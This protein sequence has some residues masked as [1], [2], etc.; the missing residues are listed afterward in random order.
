MNAEFLALCAESEIEILQPTTSGPVVGGIFG[1][2]ADFLRAW[3]DGGL[4]VGDFWTWLPVIFEL[5][6]LVGPKIQEIIKIIKDAINRGDT[7]KVFDLTAGAA[8]IP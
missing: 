6:R 8:S 3:R 5:I 4:K 2:L 7:P 1:R